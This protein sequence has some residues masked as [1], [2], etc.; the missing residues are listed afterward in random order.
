MTI[1]GT[2]HA[3]DAV[4]QGAKNDLV[5]GYNT[6]AGESPGPRCPPTSAARP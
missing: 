4:T 5:T 2:N 1:T 3:G 6:A